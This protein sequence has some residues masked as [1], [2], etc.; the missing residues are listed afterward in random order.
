MRKDQPVRTPLNDLVVILPGITGSVLERDGKAVWGASPGVVIRALL[1]RGG[2]LGDLALPDDGGVRATKLIRDVHIV[3]GLHKIDGY[4]ALIRAIENEFEIV[5]GLGG[6]PGA[7]NFL[8]FP[9]DWRQDNRLSARRLDAVVKDQLPRWRAASGAD[10]AKVILLA[11]SMGGLVSR[12]WLECLG[13]WKD[14]RALVSFGT[15]YRGSLDSLG[16]LVNGYRKAFLDL[17]P[18]MRSMP[19]A[20]QL[21][22][23]YEAI[24]VDGDWQRVTEVPTLPGVDHDLARDANKF[25]DEIADAVD[26]RRK[27]EGSLAP[28]ALTP[29][30]GTRQ[31][32][33]QS[34]TFAAGSLTVGEAPP[35]I[36]TPLLEGGD[37]TVPRV[38]A[39]PLELSDEHRETFRPERHSSLQANRAIL[40]DLVDRIRD[41]QATGLSEV[42][43]VELPPGG[44]PSLALALEDAYLPGEPVEVRARI[45]GIETPPADLRAL[46]EPVDGA[47]APRTETMHE[48]D[49]EWHLLAELDPGDYR[50]TVGMAG[51]GPLRPP[52]VH[53]VFSVLPEPEAG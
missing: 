10:D 48:R 6:D 14:C 13:G 1:S 9:Y 4:T 46:I 35:R 31:P 53:D 20:H 47:A 30:V 39:T 33:E 50:V 24:E 32:T 12:Y 38:S 2:T 19:S 16:Y 34:A 25:H 44:Q 37:G 18:V 22:P 27:D 51:G 3:P 7:T 11:H 42:R 49:G 45:L 21:L 8:E 15:P 29:V 52:D 36:V 26:A 17:S 23:I 43:A 41:L 40:E 5:R 28:Y